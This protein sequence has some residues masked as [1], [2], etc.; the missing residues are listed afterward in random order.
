MG[1]DATAPETELPAGHELLGLRVGLG[2]VPGAGTAHL[3][4]GSERMG[5]LGRI[6]SC[7]PYGHQFMSDEVVGRSSS[8]MRQVLGGGW[9]HDAAC[10]GW[11]GPPLSSSGSNTSN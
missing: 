1:L 11:V 8:L 5:S 2:L 3:T 9:R 7:P 6:N 10:G 4:V